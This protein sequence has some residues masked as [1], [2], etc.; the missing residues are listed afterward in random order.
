MPRTANDLALFWIGI[1][2]FNKTQIATASF[3][4]KPHRV[5]HP[6][7]LLVT[8]FATGSSKGRKVGQ[9]EL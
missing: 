2:F 8:D 9:D 6:R 4:A 1:F 3:I 5:P 7:P